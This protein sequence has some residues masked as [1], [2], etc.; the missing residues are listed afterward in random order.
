ML[1]NNIKSL[2]KQKGLTQKELAD[3]LHVTSQAVSRWELGDVEP[4]VDTVS[5][6]A[7]I[8]EVNVSDLISASSV[9]LGSAAVIEAASAQS[10]PQYEQI[11]P[12]IIYQQPVVE[13]VVY[14]QPKPVLAVCEVCNK[15]IYDG[16]DLF[17]DVETHRSGRSSYTTKKVMCKSCYDKKKEKERK[18][19]ELARQQQ[20]QFG[21]SRR[22]KGYVWSAIFALI[23]LG[24]GVIA[25]N[26][27]NLMTGGLI[28]LCII[29]AIMTFTF[30]SCMFMNNTFIAETF[31]SISEWGFVKMPGVIFSFDLDGIIWLITIK[32]TL[33][34]LG[35]ML[36]VGAAALAL[37]ICLVLS[38]FTYPFSL[39]ISIHEPERTETII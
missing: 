19:K 35:I 24:G 38:V 16:G 21:I 13:K 28:A 6:M 36:A 15:P 1:S 23:V 11:E 8:F 10:E 29:G 34:V 20:I 26:S 17:R 2:R 37:A 22:H 39:Y 4:S 18:Q 27:F 25:L 30:S 32:L 14:E 12:T 3:M 9:T 5:D 33:F 31:L 7:R